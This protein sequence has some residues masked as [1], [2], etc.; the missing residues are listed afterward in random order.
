MHVFWIFSFGQNHYFVFQGYS[1]FGF[2][3]FR[4]LIFKIPFQIHVICLFSFF[5]IPMLM[6]TGL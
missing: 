3:E 2:A 1:R 5:F 4:G 6:M